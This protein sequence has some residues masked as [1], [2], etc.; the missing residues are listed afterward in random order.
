MN[1][2]ACSPGLRATL[3]IPSGTPLSESPGV[4]QRPT[5]EDEGQSRGSSMGWDRLHLFHRT[6]PVS[7]PL[8][9]ESSSLTLQ[10][11]FDEGLKE[12]KKK[13]W[14]RGKG[15]RCWSVTV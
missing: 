7:N 13:G 10:N 6:N 1:V 8:L 14:N 15:Q 9:H 2:D 12:K 4:G 5:A 11:P 3:S